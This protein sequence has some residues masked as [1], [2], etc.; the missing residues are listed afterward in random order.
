MTLRTLFLMK[1]VRIRNS[2]QTQTPRKSEKHIFFPDTKVFGVTVG[3]AAHGYDIPIV[4]Q[5]L[6]ARL[7]DEAPQTA[8]LFDES[9]LSDLD[10]ENVERC[11]AAFNRGMAVDLSG[12]DANCVSILFLAFFKELPEPVIGRAVDLS[13]LTSEVDSLARAA[14]LKQILQQHVPAVNYNVL[15][16]L[17]GFLKSLHS[18]EVITGWN[19][20][21]S[22]DL[23]GPSVVA[24]YGDATTQFIVRS[25]IVNCDEYFPE[26][27]VLPEEPELPVEPVAVPA[28][29]SN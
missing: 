8:G 21:K 22:S 9:K 26:T 7:E 13:K 20:T 5:V 14:L 16:V 17:M 2:P 3:R 4:L 27:F 19:V 10:K 1:Q 23:F 18:A 15:R 11:K 25:M 24:G 6:L 28:A 12:M 29:S